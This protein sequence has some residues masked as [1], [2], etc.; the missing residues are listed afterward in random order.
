MGLT[1]EYL[2]RDFQKRA[3][4]IAIQ[5]IDMSR[6]AFAAVLKQNVPLG[7]TD[8]NKDETLMF[9]EQLAEVDPVRAA[10]ILMHDE[11]VRKKVT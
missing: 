8:L 10:A 2:T 1:A 7:R 9:M 6:D 5:R 3:L 11:D 4:E